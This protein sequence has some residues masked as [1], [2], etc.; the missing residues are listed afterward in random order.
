MA[1]QSFVNS[2]VFSPP[3][4]ANSL[5][6]VQLLQCKRYMDFVR[7]KNGQRI[8]YCHMAPGGGLVTQDR[9]DEVTRTSTVILFHHGNAEDLGGC[10]HYAAW[11]AA[12]FGVAVVMY[13]YCGYGFSGNA[14]LR[15]EVTEETVYSDADDM[16]AHVRRLGYPAHRILIVGRSVGGGP[17]CY[18]A[19]KHHTEIAGLILI[20]TFTSCLRVVST[21][22]LPFFCCCVDLFPNYHR[23]EAVT[24][25]PVL[26]VHGKDDVVVPFRCSVDLLKRITQHRTKELKRLRRRRTERGE[27]QALSSAWKASLS[28]NSNASLSESRASPKE[29]SC[30]SAARE[31]DNAYDLFLRAFAAIPE[32]IRTTA[33]RQVGFDTAAVEIGTFFK[34]IPG[35]G[36]NDIESREMETF[37]QAIMWFVR[38]AKAF[39]AERGQAIECA[40]ASMEVAA[41]H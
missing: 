40:E 4:N 35:C 38:F 25:C 30:P 36:H 9:L 7:K 28:A 20:S 5:Q 37:S 3:D 23:V 13:D 1:L 18:L 6:A 8:A 11:L 26:I 15:Q 14:G 21:S 31:P 22:C 17:A 19:E 12:S 27:G 24:A 41:S 34:W 33:A 32:E 10:F 2:I 29:S 39:S 16:Y